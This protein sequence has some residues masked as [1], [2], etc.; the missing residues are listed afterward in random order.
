M[1]CIRSTKAPHLDC[2]IVSAK[3]V[4]DVIAKGV[5]F[6]VIL[7]I[8]NPN[9]KY[10]TDFKPPDQILLLNHTATSAPLS[11]LR[12]KIIMNILNIPLIFSVM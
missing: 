8:P 2:P 6:H 9:A 4:I 10:S 12:D 5:N 11:R 1:A 3:V 7:S